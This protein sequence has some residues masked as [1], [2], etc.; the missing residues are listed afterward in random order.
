MVKQ[1]PGRIP[2]F[3]NI[4]QANRSA[5]IIGVR[6]KTIYGDRENNKKDAG[7]LS[8]AHFYFDARFCSPLPSD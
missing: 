4:I 6:A 8:L 2:V 1:N 5:R 3:S 7:R